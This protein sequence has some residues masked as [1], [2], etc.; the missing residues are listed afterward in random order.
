MSVPY[1]S[2][3]PRLELIKIRSVSKFWNQISIP[4]L[5]EKLEIRLSIEQSQT[6]RSDD[7]KEIWMDDKESMVLWN[8]KFNNKTTLFSSLGIKELMILCCEDC[9]TM[10]I[11][12]AEVKLFE[13][14]FARYG[15]QI[16]EITLRIEIYPGYK[17]HKNREKVF[18]SLFKECKSAK[19]FRFIQD[20]SESLA[21]VEVS[22]STNS[23]I[24]ASREIAS[25]KNLLKTFPN[26]A[27]ICLG[28]RTNC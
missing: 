27:K 15:N 6:R 8:E 20:C 12:E 18:Q 23:L 3:M 24:I 16:L 10:E 1:F 14:F 11:G 22:T 19:E 21:N 25:Y 17:S 4:I 26:V 9:S 28:P 7:G 2:S 13:E 5:K